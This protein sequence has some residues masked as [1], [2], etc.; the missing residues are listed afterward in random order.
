MMRKVNGIELK[1]KKNKINE[2][3]LPKEKRLE[4]IKTFVD[5]VNDKL[6][7]GNNMPQIIISYDGNEAKNMQSFGKNTPETKEIRVIDK[8]RNLADTLRT[9]GHEIKHADQ[10]V[11]GKLTPKSSDTGSDDE[12]EANAFAGVIMREFGRKYPIIF[13]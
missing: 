5:F 4:I 11:K 6:Q 9:L 8:N 7:L 10:Y 12:N 3:I 1:E 13:E 2:E